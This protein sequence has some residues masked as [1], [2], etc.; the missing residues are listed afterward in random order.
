[1]VTRIHPIGDLSTL[2]E[3]V[4]LTI[5]E[6][7]HLQLGAFPMTERML[8]RGGRPCGIYFCLHGPRAI[9]FTAIWETERNQ[10]LFYGP[11]GERFLKTQLVDTPQLE[12]AAA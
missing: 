2:R 4:N 7:N 1:M 12:L 8:S 6:H 11:D 3:Y 10:V 5:C 9:K